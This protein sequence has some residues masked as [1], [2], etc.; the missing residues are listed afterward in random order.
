MSERTRTLALTEGIVA[1]VLFGTAAIFT[2]F[3]GDLNAFSIAFWRVVT[4]SAALS[5]IL[6]FFRRSS[7]LK[8]AQKNLK[9]LFVLGIFLG[10][11]FIFFTSA[12]K[13]TTVLN[14][15]VLVNTTPIFSMFVSS[16]LF[17]VKPSRLA[18]LGLTV[19]FAG[20]CIIAY[21]DASLLG[22]SPNLKGDLEAVLAAVVEAFYLNLG[23]KIRGQTAILPIMIPIYLLTAIV[24]G[25]LSIP[26]NTLLTLPN[27]I[28]IIIP[29]ICLGLVP[30]AIAHTLYFSSLSGLKSFETATMALLEPIGATILGIVLFQELPAPLFVFGAFLILLG[31]IFVTKKQE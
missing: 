4:A 19:S 9:D 5:I 22:E 11:H 31:I 13:D 17:K 26:A 27:D 15:T 6:L 30:T 24:V 2:K 3:L 16:F 12:I 29:I 23:R 14:A 10:L 1:G 18:V 8:A 20:A 21:A 7:S 28:T 25:V